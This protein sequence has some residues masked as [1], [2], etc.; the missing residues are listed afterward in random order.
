MK[1]YTEQQVLDAYNAGNMDGRLNN[2]DYSTIDGFK[3][4]ELPSDEEIEK[5]ND[6]STKLN[7]RTYYDAFQD[8]A[9]WMKK[10][11]IKQNK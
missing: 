8:G 9:K 5:Y 10:Q 3:P 2:M 4:I 11:I 1:L 7:P 6:G